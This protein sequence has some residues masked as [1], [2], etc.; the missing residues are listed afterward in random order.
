MAPIVPFLPYEIELLR[1]INAWHTPM[2]DAF[3][4]SISNPAV[5]IPL[6]VVLLYY[7]FAGKPLREPILL[8]LC[9]LVCLAT[10]HLL[11]NV[12]AKPFFE[13][14]RPTHT[15]GIAEY[16]H[17][18]Y[19][20]RATSYSFFSGHA[21]NFF[22]V[23]TMLA[24]VVRRRAHT[25]ALFIVV[26]ITAYSRL[27]QGVHFVSDILVGI[28]VGVAVGMLFAR[29][30]GYLRVRLFGAYISSHEL[31]SPHYRLWV[32][33]VMAFVPI[34]LIFSWQVAHIISRL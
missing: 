10:C 4:Y 22:A 24:M 34:L 33:A 16:L 26:G 32:G 20:Y 31:Y 14:P 21:T 18:V 30:Y 7:L 11:S 5:W 9:L 17:I 15:P 29:L 25:W 1:H 28:I 23:A 2:L 13:R 19:G 6:V 27:Y 3:M 12:W 8:L